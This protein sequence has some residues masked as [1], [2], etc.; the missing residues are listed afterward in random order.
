MVQK[1]EDK[2][3][4]EEKDKVEG[5]QTTQKV[6]KK[7][8]EK[9]ATTTDVAIATHKDALKKVKEAK[10][11]QSVVHAAAKMQLKATKTKQ[12]KCQEKVQELEATLKEAQ[13]SIDKRT[14]MY[15]AAKS[16]DSP[17]S[18]NT[19]YFKIV[20]P[21][22]TTSVVRGP[23]GNDAA[24]QIASTKA[25]ITSAGGRRYTRRRRH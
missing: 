14:E 1:K 8:I 25:A 12:G 19:V 7:K 9:A 10:Q 17:E 11:K 16:Q 15:K 2:T 3:R 23:S 22:K 20:L 21:R 6:A 18:D 4:K 24:T 5:G 13:R